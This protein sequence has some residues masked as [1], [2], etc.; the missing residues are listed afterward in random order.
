MPA[1]AYAPQNGQVGGRNRCSVES[2]E[3]SHPPPSYEVHRDSQR[4]RCFDALGAACDK[5][6]RSLGDWVSI[7]LPRKNERICGPPTWAALDGGVLEFSTEPYSPSG[8]L[9]CVGQYGFAPTAAFPT[10]IQATIRR[11]G[12][13]LLGRFNV[14]A[15]SETTFFIKVNSP[16]L[17]FIKNDKRE[18][19]TLSL[20]DDAGCRIGSAKEHLGKNSS[21]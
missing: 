7:H 16:R 13:Q 14:Y 17:S 15:E 21:P 2:R 20:H 3:T 11:E 10:G 5:T 4:R 1:D 19:T 8:A 9:S 6:G 12:D 18:V